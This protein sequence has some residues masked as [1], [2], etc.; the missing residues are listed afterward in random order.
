M[1][2]FKSCATREVGHIILLPRNAASHIAQWEQINENDKIAV[3]RYIAFLLHEQ[4]EK[5]RSYTTNIKEA[6]KKWMP[7]PTSCAISLSESC[8]FFDSLIL[9]PASDRNRAP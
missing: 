7:N 2:G 4:A 8:L 6:R 1:R 5:N 9:Q 3:E